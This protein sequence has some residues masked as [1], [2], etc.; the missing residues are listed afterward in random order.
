MKTNDPSP[1]GNELGISEAE[2][3]VM[4]RDLE[5]IHNDVSLPALRASVDEWKETNGEESAA[6]TK[7]QSSRRTFLLGAGAAAVGG[8]AL[9]ACGSSGAAPKATTPPGTP[10][11]N[12]TG[13]ASLSGDLKVAALAAS[14]ENLG[15]FAYNAGIKAA[16]AGK[17]GS[18]PPAVVTFAQTAMS[19]HV[20]HAAAWNSVLVAA[21]K[22]KVTE[23]DPALTPTVKQM[24]S[25]VKDVTGLAEL[26][27]TIENIAAQTYQAGVSELSSAKAVAAAASIHPVEMQ[28][29][30]ILSFVLGKYPVPNAFNPTSMAR[31]TSDLG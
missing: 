3:L 14:L 6:D 11:G 1:T 21:G 10:S 12:K 5:Q 29:A 22:A 15:I 18:V 16:T 9:A 13:P 25:Q 2:L 8:L 23:T 31:S 4:T 7:R 20:Q 17:L 30:A 19:Q 28:H 24:F 27:L 26:A